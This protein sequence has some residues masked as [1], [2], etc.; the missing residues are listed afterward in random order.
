MSIDL[1]TIGVEYDTSGLLKGTAAL[2]QNEQQAGKTADAA[3]KVG[4]AAK[5][6]GEGFSALSNSLR[7]LAL[8]LVLREFIQISDQYTKY[9]A[10]L[11][12]ATQSTQEYARANAEV[13]RIAKLTEGGLGTIGVLY[14]RITNA[15][16]ELGI[17]QSQVS[18][19]SETVGL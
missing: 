8:G 15:T 17:S 9:T 1:A 2:K 7:G 6:A 16:R 4:G 14:A 11:K 3:D 18:K 12:L 19:I 5:R 13:Q 10:Q